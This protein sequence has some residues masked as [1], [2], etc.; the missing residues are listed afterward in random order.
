M[1]FSQ[2]FKT[3]NMTF[4]VTF[5][6]NSTNILTFI[7]FVNQNQC[8]KVQNS[9]LI[10]VLFISQN[11]V[12]SEENSSYM[13]YWSHLTLESE[14][15]ASLNNKVTIFQI[16]SWYLVR[17]DLQSHHYQHMTCYFGHHIWHFGHANYRGISLVPF[18]PQG[19]DFRMY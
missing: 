9:I 6:D 1:I 14:N 16:S 18:K 4:S 2:K 12:F 11:G 19:S 15:V 17:C 5:N 10:L 7:R 13:T 3:L 8:K